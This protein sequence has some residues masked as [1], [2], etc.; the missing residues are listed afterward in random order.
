MKSKRQCRKKKGK[1]E[2][3]GRSHTLRGIRRLC[4][5][6]GCVYTLCTCICILWVTHYLTYSHLSNVQHYVH[7]K[8]EFSWG[9]YSYEEYS[10]QINKLIK[11]KIAGKV[12]AGL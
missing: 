4:G 11:L 3:E 12:I 5:M 7:L 6:V 10:R 9:L 2:T 8:S 1:V